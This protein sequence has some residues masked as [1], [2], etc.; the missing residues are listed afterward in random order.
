MHA[1]LAT[2]GSR[3]GA[4]LALVLALGLA[5]PAAAQ[6]QAPNG[7]PT[8]DGW[9]I[10]VPLL[11][12]SSEQ[13]VAAVG[14]RIYLLGGYPPGRIPVDTVQV[15]DAATDRWSYGPPLPDP[16]H[17]VMAAG[18]GDT[19]Y[20][21]GGE[22]GDAGTGQPDV[23]LSNVYKLE[24]QATD[25]TPLA[26]MPAARGAG[27]TAVVDGKIYVAGGRFGAG[28]DSQ[29][30][31]ALEIYDPSTSAWSS[32]APMPTPRGGVA[33]VEANGCLFVIGGEGN[34]SDP[35]GLFVQNEAYDPRSDSWTSLSP[36]PTPTHGLVGAAFVNGL[37]HIPGG[38]V[39]MGGGS[40][41]VIHQV[42]RPEISCR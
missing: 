9:A 38:S 14:S 4:A 25:W 5:V 22:T 35:R 8:V 10:A 6:E 32:S 36:M 34:Y 20:A 11:A 18:V 30:T 42:Y 12:P 16:A 41:S 7:L 19:L 27:G 28:F 3:L 13:A 15:Y 39:T 37:I 2:C 29:K 31:P 24:P 17:H 33:G 23:F 1:G 26:A 40:G 21:I